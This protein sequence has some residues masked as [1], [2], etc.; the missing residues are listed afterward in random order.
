[1]LLFPIVYG[2]FPR[3]RKLKTDWPSIESPPKFSTSS[4]TTNDPKFSTS[5]KTINDPKFS[6]SSKTTNDQKFSTSSK[7]TNDPDIRLTQDDVDPAED[8]DCFTEVVDECEDVCD[9]CRDVG[10]KA[11]EEV[12]LFYS[13]FHKS[14]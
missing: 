6:T 5:S 1:M 7:T 11:V 10:P 14:I 9:N 2:G 8:K 12:S 3:W 4:K 13:V